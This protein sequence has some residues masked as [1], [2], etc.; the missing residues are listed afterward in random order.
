MSTSALEVAD[1]KEVANV[2]RQVIDNFVCIFVINLRYGPPQ[3]R[4]C[5]ACFGSIQVAEEF[6]DFDTPPTVSLQAQN[7]ESTTVSCQQFYIFATLVPSGLEQKL[8][9]QCESCLEQLHQS[10]WGRYG[11]WCRLPTM[12][13]WIMANRWSAPRWRADH[14]RPPSCSCHEAWPVGP[15]SRHTRASVRSGPTARARSLP[16][17]C[18]T[19]VAPVWVIV[20]RR[21]CPGTQMSVVR[22]SWWEF[23]NWVGPRIRCGWDCQLCSAVPCLQPHCTTLPRWTWPRQ[24]TRQGSRKLRL[25]TTHRKPQE[26]FSPQTES[27]VLPTSWSA[28]QF[29]AQFPVAP[30]IPPRTVSVALIM[31]SSCPTACW[32]DWLGGRT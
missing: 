19:T 23:A 5:F 13:P 29:C 2:L 15:A 20:Q 12:P 14:W 10:L 4:R 31:P 18:E 9:H 21:S 3:S 30:E 16:Q 32:T 27:Q 17:W 6:R 7:N 8:H 25:P 11:L 28:M 22:R 24:G 1:I 26:P